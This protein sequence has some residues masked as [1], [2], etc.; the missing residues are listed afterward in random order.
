M[1]ELKQYFARELRRIDAHLEE[2]V[3]GLEGFVREV[4]AFALLSPGKRLRPLMTMLTARA[5]GYSD[6]KELPLACSLEM[7]HS[8]TLLHDDILDGADLRRG[9]DSAHVRFG[10]KET[11]LA[12]D[13]LLALAN[14]IGASYA[15][16]RISYHLAEGIMETAIGEIK[17][18]AA[19]ETP[20]A[21]REEYLDI[22]TGKT[23]C[24]L[25][26]ACR[27]GAVLA[28]ASEEQEETA[29]GFGLGVGIAFQLVDD[30]LDYEG[31]AEDIGKPAGS[32]LREGKITW[33][34]LLYMET[35][36]SEEA[37]E[38]LR[39]VG[40]RS[41]APDRLED[42]VEKVRGAGLGQKTRRYAGGYVEE[43]K[44]HLR[45]FPE[46]PERTILEQAADFVL[47]R[48]K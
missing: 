48:S 34:L 1:K 2:Q 36:S 38:F 3:A 44:S 28:G 26:T 45:A 15:N 12:G 8:A 7:L 9:E 31:S 39:A 27:L 35:L 6:D 17:E 18:I 43:A 5:L 42:V 19:L 14:K 47:L 4:A 37:G 16:P 21:S 30:A 33:P 40:S 29:A 13:A 10:E 41:L 25:K 46:S 22:I 23:A 20:T 11:I 32:D 24:L